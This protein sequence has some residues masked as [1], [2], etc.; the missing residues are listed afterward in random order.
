MT[1]STLAS[2]FQDLS[3]VVAPEDVRLSGAWAGKGDAPS[4]VEFRVA[5]AA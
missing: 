3:L 4:A 5:A 1:T 2:Y